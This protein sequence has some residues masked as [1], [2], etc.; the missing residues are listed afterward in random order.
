MLTFVQD[1]RGGS[2]SPGA[3]AGE[4]PDRLGSAS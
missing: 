4:R 1:I 2:A 3:I